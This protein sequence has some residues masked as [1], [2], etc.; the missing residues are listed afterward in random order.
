MLINSMIDC[1]KGG[2]AAALV[3][4]CIISNK[5]VEIQFEKIKTSCIRIDETLFSET[6]GRMIITTDKS[7]SIKL[8]DLAKKNGVSCDIIG[9][10]GKNGFIISHFN[11]NLVSLEINQ[12]KESWYNTI[13]NYMD[14]SL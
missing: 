1:S 2:L 13:P 9:K 4:M 12:V 5:G 6:H 8:N 11:K 3:K 7:N 10:M 14:G